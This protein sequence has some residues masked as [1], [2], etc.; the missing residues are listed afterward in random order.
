LVDINVSLMFHIRQIKHNKEDTM[1][2]SIEKIKDMAKQLTLDISESAEGPSKEQLHKGALE[3]LL[4]IYQLETI[5]I[6]SYFGAK[7][8]SKQSKHSNLDKNNDEATIKDEINKL[9][10]RI[11]LWAKRQHQ[12]NSRILTLFLKMKD[13]GLV[14]ITEEMLLDRYETKSEFYTNFQQ[15]KAIAPNNHGKVFD[16]DG[17]VVAIWEPVRQLVQDYK[18]I[19]LGK[20]LRT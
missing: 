16:V 9:H 11:P 19:V 13:E 6:Q 3:L 4:E 17:G 8:V 2:N 10:R 15:M 1:K 12:I 7:K 20:N 14:S 5:Y 18:K